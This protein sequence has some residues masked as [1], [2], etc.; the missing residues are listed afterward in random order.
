MRQNLELEISLSLSLSL[1]V[2]Q[3]F[4]TQPKR[5]NVCLSQYT[6]LSSDTIACVCVC[7]CRER[8]KELERHFKID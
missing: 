4:E 7:V 1:S 5:S 8:E 6:V 2:P 3:N